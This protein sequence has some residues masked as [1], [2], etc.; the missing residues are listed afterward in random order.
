[1][2]WFRRKPKTEDR[3]LH[4][5]E[6]PL[7][8]PSVPLTT[9]PITEANQYNALQIADAY[10]C[11]RALADSVAS[12]PVRVYRDT[13]NGRQ[14]AGPD[15][16]LVRLLQHPSPGSTR[17]DLFSQIM[18]HLAIAGNA[19]IAK[20]RMDGQIISLSLLPPDT[21]QV[22]L[23]GEQIIYQV[24][25][26]SQDTTFFSP[27]DVLHVKAMGGLDIGIRGLSPVS[28]A[29]LALTLSANL[30]ESSHQFFASGSRPS[31]I[32]N[33]KSPQSDFSIEQVRESW[34]NRH[35]STLNMFRTA[36]LSGEVQYQP[37]SF[38]PD[39]MQFLQQRE[40][41]A[42]EVARIFGIPPR[43]IGAAEPHASKTYANVTMENIEF[44]TYSLRPWLVRIEEAIN[45]D[46][47]LAAGN[48]YM[49][50]D[51][52]GLLRADPD[53]RSQ[54]WQRA[55]GSTT[56]GQPAWMTVDEVRAAE[57]LV[58]MAQ[59]QAQPLPETNTPAAGAAAAER[60]RTR[61]ARRRLPR[62]S[63]TVMTWDGSP[64]RFTDEQYARSAA[65]DRGPDFSGN[66]KERYGLPVREPDGTL[67]CD[68]VTAA[69]QRFNQVKGASPE[70]LATARRKLEQ[71]AAQ[72]EKRSRPLGE[73]EERQLELSTDGQK[74]RGVIPYGTRS[75]DMGGWSE[76]IE[77]TAL[78]STRLDDLVVTVDHAG[79]PLGRY[80][81]T[82]DVEDRA[83]GMHWSVTPPVSRADVIEAI[84]RGDLNGGSWRMRV[85]RDEWRG[86][87][88]HVHEIA[89]LR[90][91][92][93]VT[94]PSYPAAA[95][96][97]RHR[98]EEPTVPEV[99]STPSEPAASAPE[100]RSAPDPVS[101][102]PPE[103][104]APS[105][106]LLRVE[107]RSGGDEL[108][109]MLSECF[110]RRGFPTG[111]AEVP[112]SEYASRS[113]GGGALPRWE[114]RDVTYT[115]G[116]SL[117]TMM[118]VAG[119]PL[120]WDLR[121]TWPAFASRAIGFDTTSITI[122]RQVSRTLSDPSV[123]RPIDA[124]T[125]KPEVNSVIESVNVAPN[126]IAAVESNVPAIYLLQP[127]VDTLINS[128]LRLDLNEKLDYQCVQ[129][130]T[131]N[132]TQHQDPTGVDLFVAIRKAVTTLRA[133]GYNPDTLILTPAASESIDLFKATAADSFYL[134][135][136]NFSES[137]I[138]DLE[139]R[140]SKAIPAPYVCDA[141]ALGFNYA[142]PVALANFEANSGLTNGRNVRMEMNYLFGIERPKAAVRIAAS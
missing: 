60:H 117:S 138:F 6:W 95:V 7:Y 99:T 57:D 142:T 70:Q 65:L 90:D 72:C 141:S 54:L 11:V 128:D 79:L 28:Q 103:P 111:R 123:I 135:A 136:P 84:Q 18:V 104:P 97:L 110:I 116:L 31:G 53:A 96:E 36:V 4:P 132:V 108:P 118:Q 27:S 102:T 14:A 29:R 66:A 115:P 35:S 22:M 40:L 9:E 23:R 137:S 68:A 45:G 124:T 75:V 41:S 30:Q 2:A 106:G 12:L 43:R 109:R 113:L 89:E 129:A 107:A 58:P 140:E 51:L 62:R 59:A 139:K 56:A 86:D 105:Q 48:L 49:R 39:D 63:D 85:G 133:A 61:T 122:R 78:R 10:A 127:M 16:R 24:W 42:R 13:G 33:V 101:S 26:P 80:P 88:R 83:D 17:C 92:S 87:V 25:L 55:L 1:V 74:I 37:I 73:F 93:I 125:Q 38:S 64:S 114:N 34:D 21:V 5:V 119:A 50:F 76:V 19:F 15:T 71:L 69:R 77:P 82:L 94:H 120:G 52:D 8:A 20:W 134:S 81:R 32:L 112:W 47:D 131:S 91:V 44:L 98:T 100:A 121:Y 46:S 3:D 67:N 126:Q 130:L